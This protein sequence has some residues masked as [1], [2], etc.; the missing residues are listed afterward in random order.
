MMVHRTP[1]F[2][3]LTTNGKTL[4]LTNILFGSPWLSLTSHSNVSLSPCECP[5]ATVLRCLVV[6]FSML[7]GLLSLSSPPQSLVPCLW[8]RL[9]Y[10]SFNCH[11]CL[12]SH[13]GRRCLLEVCEQMVSTRNPGLSAVFL[14]RRFPLSW[15]TKYE[16]RNAKALNQIFCDLN[17]GHSDSSHL[18]WPNMLHM[19]ASLG[20]GAA[21]DQRTWT[22]ALWDAVFTSPWLSQG[23][24]VGMKRTGPLYRS[25]NSF[26]GLSWEWNWDFK[27]N[28]GLWTKKQTTQA[29]ALFPTCENWSSLKSYL[30]INVTV[31]R[32][33]PKI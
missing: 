21:R 32:I 24:S 22:K 27:N 14:A 13:F 5:E 15:V 18:P 11:M 28:C 20:Y 23:I 1:L 2:S 33:S 4:P 7:D 6:L 12:D 8:W 31:S 9:V 29:W 19:A 17:P 30:Y 16:E 26:A 10:L 25:I 3:P